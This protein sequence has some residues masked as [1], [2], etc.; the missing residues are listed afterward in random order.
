MG[1]PYFESTLQRV[2]GVSSGAVCLKGTGIMA[3]FVASRFAAGETAESIASDYGVPLCH[4]EA[5]IRLVLLVNGTALWSK[6]ALK[7][8]D[9]FVPMERR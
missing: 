6:R 1:N 5:A 7:R 3:E 2:D 9:Q 8:L 4:V